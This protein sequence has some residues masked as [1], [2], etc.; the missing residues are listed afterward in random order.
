V[1]CIWWRICLERRPPEC[2]YG[3][4]IPDTGKCLPGGTSFPIVVF[5]LD[6]ETLCGPPG[7][8]TTGSSQSLPLQ[9]ALS[10]QRVTLKKTHIRPGSTIYSGLTSNLLQC[11]C[12][13]NYGTIEVFCHS[14]KAPLVEGHNYWRSHSLQ[15]PR[16]CHRRDQIIAVIS[17]RN[18]GRSNGNEK[19]EMLALRSSG[20][21]I[22]LTTWRI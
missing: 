22:A 16:S 6:T 11:R 21:P 20:Q 14:C 3:E 18:G 2:C 1:S 12:G 8:E 15:F 4:T 10:G 9:S 13:Q 5:A 7:P 17:D 19:G